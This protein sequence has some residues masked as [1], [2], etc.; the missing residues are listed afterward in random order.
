[1][2]AASAQPLPVGY[3]IKIHQFT[4]TIH[5]DQYPSIDP[6]SLKLSRKGETVIVTGSGQGI[7]KVSLSPFLM[8]PICIFYTTFG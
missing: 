5:G 3:F 1:M 8:L 7:G 4:K 2:A 6:A